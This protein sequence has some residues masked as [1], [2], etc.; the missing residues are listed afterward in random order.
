MVSGEFSEAA[1]SVAAAFDGV[2]EG[3]WQRTGRRSNGSVFTIETLGQYLMHD[4]THH[5]HDVRG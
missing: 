5:L 1:E 3:D 4:L 2:G